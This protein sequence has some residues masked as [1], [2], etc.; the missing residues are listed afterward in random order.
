MTRR[1]VYQYIDYLDIKD[2][3]KA[4]T[5]YN[6]TILKTDFLVE[7]VQDYMIQNGRAGVEFCTQPVYHTPI[8]ED[9]MESQ[10][11]PLEFLR[12]ELKAE[13]RK[14]NKAMDS[15]RRQFQAVIEA[16]SG[17]VVDIYQKELEGLKNKNNDIKEQTNGK[18]EDAKVL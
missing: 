7:F 11:V 12:S 15:I 4:N 13:I 18:E 17:K 14:L 5:G 2:L 6:Y 1:E 9:I 8:A 10:E 3:I 16:F